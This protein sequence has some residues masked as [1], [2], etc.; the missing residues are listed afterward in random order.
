[1][2]I[3]RSCLLLIAV[4]VLANAV[5][6]LPHHPVGQIYDESQTVTL[7]GE[8]VRLVYRNPHSLLHLE[9]A[10]QGGVDHTWA[11]EWRGVDR[12]RRG[13]VGARY[14]ATGRPRR[15]LWESRTGTRA[16]T[17]CGYSR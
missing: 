3:T 9:V 13:G 17:D 10:S 12:L 6:V 16:S 8:I 4:A 14:A 1:M 7:E 2:T 5:P 15:G 11:I